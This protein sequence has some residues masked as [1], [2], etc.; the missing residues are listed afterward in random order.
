MTPLE[1]KAIAGAVT[2]FTSAAITDLHAALV[3]WKCWADIAR[4]DWGVATFR[5]AQ[6]TLAGIVTGLGLGQ[7]M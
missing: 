6:G 4:Y 3:S 2:G 7:V 5:W 1:S